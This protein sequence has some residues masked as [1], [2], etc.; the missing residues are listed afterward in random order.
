MIISRTPLR[1]SFFG[2]GTHLPEHY[3]NNGGAVIGTT[4]DKYVYHT[5]S[6]FPS[7]LF[8]YSVRISY[9][10]VECVQ[11]TEE[12]EHKPF[13]E[14]LKFMDISKDVEIHVASDLPSFSG[15]GSSSAF[16]VG[17]L[18]A[19]HNFKRTFVSQSQLTQKA[20]HLEREILKESVGCQDQTFA[21]HGGFN[22]INFGKN[23]EIKID[24]VKI[25]PE[26]ETELS[27]SLLLFFTGITRRAQVVESNKIKNIELIRD[28]LRALRMH[29]D[30]AYKI[31]T[32]N[33]SLENFG[34][35][36]DKTWREKRQLDP[37]VTNDTINSMYQKALN[38]GAIGGK[39]LGAGGGGFMLFYVPKDRQ[40]KFRLAMTSYH[41]VN[42]NINTPGSEIIYKKNEYI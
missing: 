42:F 30:E 26:K 41:E 24:P 22:L 11:S 28:S 3:K 39:L 33:A 4:I 8:D 36:L 35:L 9:S 21:A 25:I 5:V 10:K 14:I 2:G 18:N 29:V 17:L 6:K 16:T 34:L 12:I 31:L 37:G 27:D 23:G 38:S 20:I 32:G 40:E 13:R 15:L 7:K 1:V 19:L